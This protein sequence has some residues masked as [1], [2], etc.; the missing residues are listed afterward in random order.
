[1]SSFF[2]SDGESMLFKIDFVISDK[3]CEFLNYYTNVIK[4]V[5]I[6]YNIVDM[7]MKKIKFVIDINIYSK[8]DK[9]RS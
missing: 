9:D 6:T 3:F 5:V 1:M 2:K 7:L 8:Y 4:N